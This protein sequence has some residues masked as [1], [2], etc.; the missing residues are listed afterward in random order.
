MNNPFDQL[1]NDFRELVGTTAPNIVCDPHKVGAVVK[2]FRNAVVDAPERGDIPG[3]VA[4][5][6][7][8]DIKCFNAILKSVTSTPLM[9]KGSVEEVHQLRCTAAVLLEISNQEEETVS[10]QNLHRHGWDALNRDAKGKC[11]WVLTCEAS[12]EAS[13]SALRE[14]VSAKALIGRLVAGGNRPSTTML[15]VTDRDPIIKPRIDD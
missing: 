6:V 5:T 2:S 1:I 15:K 9:F 7:G 12:P 4:E 13:E 3:E 11:I 14:L 8:K 10:N